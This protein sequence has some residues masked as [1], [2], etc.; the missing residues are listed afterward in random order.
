MRNKIAI[1]LFREDAVSLGT[2]FSEMTVQ[3][4][5]RFNPAHAHIES[6][7]YEWQ[8]DCWVL[9][10]VHGEFP[11]VLVGDLITVYDRE[12]AKAR[13]PFLF[14]DTNPILYRKF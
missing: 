14:A 9:I 7:H 1:H 8:R 5:F 4:I 2:K 11:E 10:L 6:L 12:Y 3:D 13:F